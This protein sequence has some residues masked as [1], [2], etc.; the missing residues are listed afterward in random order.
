MCCALAQEDTASCHQVTVIKP[1]PYF[2]AHCK[3]SENVRWTLKMLMR[4]CWHQ[5]EKELLGGPAETRKVGAEWHRRRGTA[6]LCRDCGQEDTSVPL[7]AA[8]SS[9]WLSFSHFLAATAAPYVS[10]LC[11]S[12]SRKGGGHWGERSVVAGPPRYF[13]RWGMRGRRICL[14]RD[15]K[16]ILV[17][18][19]I[20]LLE[21]L[22]LQ[23][24][25]KHKGFFFFFFFF[26][27]TL[28]FFPSFFPS[29]FLSFLFCFLLLHLF[30]L[31]FFLFF[32]LFPFSYL[33]TVF[34]FLIFSL[35]FCFS[36]SYRHTNIH[37]NTGHFSRKH[38]SI[39]WW[40]KA[41]RTLNSIKNGAIAPPV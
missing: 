20:T 34:L 10:F 18:V 30:S 15:P 19:L 25:R 9:A 38:Y 28:S 1:S 21:Q 8:L 14:P 13:S 33:L 29:S 7:A 41:P 16:Q 3:C 22:N 5:L 40:Q 11:Y 6:P 24:I 36:L 35:F 27:L 23:N 31:S 17:W 32:L 2:Q 12:A 37:T 39:L 26:L 4:I